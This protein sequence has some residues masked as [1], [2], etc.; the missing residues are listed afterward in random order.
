MIDIPSSSSLTLQGNENSNNNNNNN[1]NS[2]QDYY[3]GDKEKPNS[4]A[5][6]TPLQ[7]AVLSCAT[8]IAVVALSWLLF[9]TYAENTSIR[10]QHEGVIADAVISQSTLDAKVTT[11]HKLLLDLTTDV[12]ELLA[13][14]KENEA[15]YNKMETHW[16]TIHREQLIPEINKLKSGLQEVTKLADS[17]YKNMQKALGMSSES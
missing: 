6:L 9:T 4:V 8:L 16:M 5:Y 13:M 14:E 17:S 11:L 7:T 3:T 15:E 2:A 1:N 12:N 10:L